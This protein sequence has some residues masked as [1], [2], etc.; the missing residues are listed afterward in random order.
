MAV[1]IGALSAQ[2]YVPLVRE[3][4]KWTYLEQYFDNQEGQNDS[5]YYT[6]EFRGDTVINGLTYKKCFQY[7]ER[8]EVPWSLVFVSE[9]EPYAFV[10]EENRCVRM[11]LDYDDVIRGEALDKYMNWEVL[12]FDETTDEIIVYDFNNPKGFAFSHTMELNDELLNVYQSQA[13]SRDGLLIE[14][15]GYV[16]DRLGD[17]LCPEFTFSPSTQY[18]TTGLSHVADAEGNVIFKGPNYSVE[19]TFGDLNNDGVVDVSDVNII[20]DAVLGKIDMASVGDYDLT[21]DG[22]VDVADVNAL[23]DIV[24]GK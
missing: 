9:T 2:A 5:R 20:I 13:I 6:I 22:N 10:R 24:L 14:S 12:D 18:R 15:I 7:A 8:E 23:I 1:L 16:H 17:L 3:G 19:N 11:L 21:D 4:V